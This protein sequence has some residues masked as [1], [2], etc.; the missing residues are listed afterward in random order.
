M[1]KET[2]K[3]FNL[4][5]FLYEHEEAVYLACILGWLSFLAA[6][7]V[8]GFKISKGNVKRF[9]WNGPGEL[10]S[11]AGT[12]KSGKQSAWFKD[13]PID[14]LV[15]FAKEFTKKT[16]FEKPVSVT[17]WERWILLLRPEGPGKNS[18]GLYLFRLATSRIFR[19]EH[20]E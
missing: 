4:S 20:F 6:A 16:R 19:K 18:W 15:E 12:C 3:K 7:S 5:E 10:K 14:E 9:D 13:V 8:V 1:E 17:I 2:K 11:I